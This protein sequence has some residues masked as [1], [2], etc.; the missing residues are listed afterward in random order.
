MSYV[1]NNNINNLKWC[2]FITAEE[3][4]SSIRNHIL[5]VNSE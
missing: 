1:G 3:A 5:G 4:N 2:D